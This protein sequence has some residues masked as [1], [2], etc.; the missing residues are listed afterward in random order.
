MNF[1]RRYVYRII[2]WPLLLILSLYHIPRFL[3]KKNV[4]K[5]AALLC[6][7]HSGLLD[8]A[9]MILGSGEREVP[10]I[11]A[12]QEALRVPVFG[13]LLRAF[14]AFPV[15]REGADINAIKLS[16]KHLKDGDK[17]LIFPEGT[18]VKK[19]KQV[20]PKQGAVLLAHKTG[21]PIVPIYLTPNRKPFQ[22]I[23]CVYGEP[24][25]PEFA[26]RRPTSE[27]LE[28]RT[29]ELMQRIYGLAEV[30]K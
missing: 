30:K 7:N 24:Y 23:K 2:R 6:G 27:E 25:H 5:G 20:E 15:D 9:W 19:G 8:P 21:V 28:L 3:R 14:G 16:L 22:P 11:M 29:Q 18:R 12:K 17:L 26:G 13:R 1:V 4:P 10:W